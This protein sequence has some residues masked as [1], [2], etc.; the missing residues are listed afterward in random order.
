M[1]VVT[2]IHGGRPACSMETFIHSHTPLGPQPSSMTTRPCVRA[3]GLT[4]RADLRTC[5]VCTALYP[6]QGAEGINPLYSA[7]RMLGA[8]GGN[9]VSLSMYI[10]P[11]EGGAAGILHS[12]RAF[13][14]GSRHYRT[15]PSLAMLQ[16]YL[17]LANQMD[18]HTIIAPDPCTRASRSSAMMLGT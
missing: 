12:P 14:Q 5:R 16:L 6:V 7:V 4:N 9:G 11:Y 2:G 3:C 8:S 15:F 13:H 17:T 18:M 10:E 1:I